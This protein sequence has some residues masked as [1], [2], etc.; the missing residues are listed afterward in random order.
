MT[1]SERKENV[2]GFFSSQYHR[3][4]RSFRAKYAELSVMEVE[5]V[6]SDM[7]VD[8]FDKIDISEQV[9]NVGAYIY[10]SIQNRM[11]DYLRRRKKSVSLDETIAN[12]YNESENAFA[13]WNDDMQSEL[14]TREAR[15]RLTEALDKLEAKQRAIWIATEVDGYSFKELSEEWSIP[16]GTL[17]SRKHRAVAALQIELH[18]LKSK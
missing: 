16:I 13:E 11:I 8:L 5:D 1:V 3:L 12:S 10:R 4:V 17:L 15:A 18:D 6:V 9:E 2:T 14:D 7:M